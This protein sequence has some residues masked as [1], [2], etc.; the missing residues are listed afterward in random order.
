M[1]FYLLFYNILCICMLSCRFLN[2][3]NIHV[4]RDAYQKL[5][6]VLNNH[7]TTDSADFFE[8]VEETNHLKHVRLVLQACLEMVTI[9]DRH[10]V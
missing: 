6:K 3:E 8:K 10:K 9:I 1:H 7:K 5:G 4:M 2:I